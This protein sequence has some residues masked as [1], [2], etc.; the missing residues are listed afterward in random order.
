MSVFCIW[1]PA[2][3]ARGGHITD[4]G[5]QTKYG[6]DRDNPHRDNAVDSGTDAPGDAVGDGILNFL[7]C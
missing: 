4:G 1:E 3:S 2:G 7:L 5:G 6:N